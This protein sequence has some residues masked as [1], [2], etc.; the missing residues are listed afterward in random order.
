[1]KEPRSVCRFDMLVAAGLQADRVT[2]N[3]LLKAC[4]RGNL[5]DKALHTFQ[6]MQQLKL[7]VGPLHLPNSAQQGFAPSAVLCCPFLH[8]EWSIFVALF[9][10][11]TGVVE[12]PF[13]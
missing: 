11:Q 5:P 4:M 9:A 13:N 7:P 6:H 8:R 1:M 2:F 3:T 12:Q 10:S